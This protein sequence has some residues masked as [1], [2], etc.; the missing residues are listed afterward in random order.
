MRP[1]TVE[2]RVVYSIRCA[3]STPL[4]CA[5]LSC[6]KSNC[7]SAIDGS[8]VDRTCAARA[9]DT[10]GYSASCFENGD[11]HRGTSRSRRQVARVK[12]YISADM[13]GVAGITSVEQTNP[14]GQPEYA[15]SCELMTGEVNA[16]CEG[17]LD[18]GATEILV[19]DS[20]WNMRNII[21]EKL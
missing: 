17:A 2:R 5:L 20:H 14:V 11:L 4:K 10:T 7:R 21:H 16:A 1:V 13:E 8:A 9:K 15:H 3:R 18:G 19:N 12:V 6:A